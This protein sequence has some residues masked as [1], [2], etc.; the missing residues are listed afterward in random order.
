MN[1]QSTTINIR[2]I[3]V[4]NI[5]ILYS[6]QCKERLKILKTINIQN[7][8]STLS[9]ISFTIEDGILKSV[10]NIKKYAFVFQVVLFPL[11]VTHNATADYF[12]LSAF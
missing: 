12:K 4:D 3:L 6:T 9:K 10:W 2:Q 1:D 7:K 11:T 5:K 8:P